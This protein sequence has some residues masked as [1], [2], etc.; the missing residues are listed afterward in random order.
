MKVLIEAPILTKSGYGEHAKLVY[1][2]LKQKNNL[3]I[4]IN[5]LNWLNNY[6]TKR[7]SK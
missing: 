4:F 2:A 5:H 6:K 7:L 3:E 1:E